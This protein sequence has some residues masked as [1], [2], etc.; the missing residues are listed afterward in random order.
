MTIL[1]HKTFDSFKARIITSTGKI[2]FTANCTSGEIAAAKADVQK[3]YG[4]EKSQ[5]VYEIKDPA[6]LE[7]RGINKYMANPQRKQT[8]TVFGFKL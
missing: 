1:V 7:R 3:A 8:F 2:T 6:E 4:L 5:T